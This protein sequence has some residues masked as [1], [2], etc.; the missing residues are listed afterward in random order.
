MRFGTRVL[1]MVDLRATLGR[2]AA[3]TPTTAAPTAAPDGGPTAGPTAGVVVIDGQMAHRVAL[4]MTK[5]PGPD[6]KDER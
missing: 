3:T 5:L 2:L 1:P 4:T 6:G